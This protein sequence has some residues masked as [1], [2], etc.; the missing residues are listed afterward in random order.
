MGELTHIKEAVG[1]V[2]GKIKKDEELKP[3]PFCGGKMEADGIA[4]CTDG[5]CSV[6]CDDCGCLGPFKGSEDEARSS[7]NKRSE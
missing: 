1:R 3:C 7:W 5:T 6:E 4:T 2:M